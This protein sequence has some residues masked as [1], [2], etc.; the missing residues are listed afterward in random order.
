MVSK[1]QDINLRKIR[2]ITGDS[3]TP[4]PGTRVSFYFDYTLSTSISGRSKMPTL[5]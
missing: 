4:I 5:S 1:P 2:T 3:R